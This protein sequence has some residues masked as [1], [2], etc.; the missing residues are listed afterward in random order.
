M[1]DFLHK[2][3]PPTPPVVAQGTKL[4]QG[5]PCPAASLK[6]DALTVARVVSEA[7]KHSPEP[8]P[9]V[10]HPNGSEERLLI[11]GAL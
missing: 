8:P 11:G 1:I 6:P 4:P 3:T 10:V 2:P 7:R 9:M 5:C